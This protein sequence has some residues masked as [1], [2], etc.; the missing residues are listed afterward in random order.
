MNLLLRKAIRMIYT[1]L[2]SPIGDLLVVGD[3]EAITA[4]YTAEHVRR[5]VPDGHRDDEAFEG[6]R[7]QLTEY[8]SGLRQSFELDLHPA[9][10]EFQRA[11]WA[12]LRRI[13]YGSTASYA[14]IAQRVGRPAA[15]RAVGA[16]NGR[17]P[18][19]IIVPCHRVVGSDGR[20][21]GY[22]GGLAAKQ[23]LL[24]HERSGMAGRG[25]QPARAVSARSR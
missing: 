20:L 8:F 10:T 12:E 16:A 24:E 7:Q 4:L 5:P 18:I 23:W 22:A 15:V 25:G 17:N 21:T 1:H 11:V 19:S 14:Q 9:G 6:A 3:G 13:E 2:E